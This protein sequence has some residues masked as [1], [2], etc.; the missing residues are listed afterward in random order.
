MNSSMKDFLYASSVGIHFVLCTIVGLGMGYFLDKTFGTFPYLSV[1]FFFMGIAAGIRE[2]LRIAK[3]ERQK[4]RD[5]G[6]LGQ[7]PKED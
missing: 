5:E 7:K 3:K 4:D 2:L 6:Q 1:I